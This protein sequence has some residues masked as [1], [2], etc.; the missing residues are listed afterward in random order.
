[1]AASLRARIMAGELTPGTQLPSTAHLVD[2]FGVSNTTV[3]KALAVLK[4]EGYLTSRQGKGVFVRDRQPFRIEA[5]AYSE[6]APGGYSYELLGVG[7]VVAPPEVAG[8]FGLTAG[9]RVQMRHRLLRRG[10]RPVE[11]DW[12]YYPLEL[13]RGTELAERRRIRGGAPRVLAE[14]GLP[15]R[16]HVDAVSARMP[17]DEEAD[18]LSLPNV[19]VI[20]Q[21]RVVYSDEDRP[22]EVS[23]LIKGSHLYE[24]LYRL[25]V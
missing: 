6:P 12:S 16:H 8:A 24:L 20:R 4:G 25:S 13:A 18:L 7:E 15:Q 10:G 23:I 5:G 11:V 1:M 22:V 14:A 19:P 3:Q 2:E 9:E 17:T 21:F